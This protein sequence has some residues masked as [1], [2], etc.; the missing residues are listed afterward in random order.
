MKKQLKWWYATG[1]C[2]LFIGI[3]ILRAHLACMT[4]DEVKTY[5][6]YV[7]NIDLYNL[8]PSVTEIIK[9]S[10]ANNH[11]LNTTLIYLTQLITG[12]RY[13]EFII[14]LPS[15]CFG[16]LYAAVC[17]ISY[18][19]GKMSLLEMSLFLLNWHVSE[20]LSI[21][22][23]YGMASCL[24]LIALIYI[25]RYAE[26]D[27]KN[28]K[29]LNLALL[30]LTLAAGA[31]TISLLLTG[32]LFFYIAYQMLRNNKMT[33]YLKRAWYCYV[34][35]GICNVG[36]ILF[37]F[38]VS[39]DGKPLYVGSGNVV[40][41][42]LGRFVAIYTDDHFVRGT[43]WGVVLFIVI[44]CVLMKRD[45]RKTLFCDIFASFFVIVFALQLFLKKGIPVER[46]AIPFYPLFIFCIVEC[47]SFWNE[48]VSVLV[49]ERGVRGWHIAKNIM[50]ALV[51]AILIVMFLKNTDLY[52]VRYWD[53]ERKIK[54]TA[55]EAMGRPIVDRTTLN[56]E[57]HE[58][59]MR[60]YHQKILLENGYDIYEGKYYGL[61]AYMDSPESISHNYII[62]FEGKEA[63]EN[64]EILEFLDS[65]GI[66]IGR[67]NENIDFC[68][69]QKDRDIE[70]LYDCNYSGSTQKTEAGV[71]SIF[72]DE[73]GNYGVYLDADECYVVKTEDSDGIIMRI[74]CW[75]GEISDGAEVT[76]FYYDEEFDR[77]VPKTDE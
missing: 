46:T 57:R 74:L 36:L 5:M 52:S 75:D 45:H 39:A 63:A 13:D 70:Y 4:W 53:D 26:S 30:F 8:I 31:N 71:L 32:S 41:T 7:C 77:I 10:A 27:W 54:R 35:I 47:I 25:R 60:F 51:C 3:L 55:Y 68:I 59:P 50:T 11:I 23:G 69:I 22:R 66:D 2:G 64:Q 9:N 33:D 28:F 58:Y 12:I 17:L 44:S 48:K 29:Q 49:E 42:V 43:V 76:C 38:Y 15:V 6:S 18:K 19:K 72:Y 1:I 65:H 56:D 67:I 40:E 21:A 73:E 14:R 16:I 61:D 34:P 24:V 37:H 20:F 62:E